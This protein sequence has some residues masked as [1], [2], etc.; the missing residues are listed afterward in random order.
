MN[1]PYL[2]L[3]RV[4]KR[5]VVVLMVLSLCFG[6]L[7]Q[8]QTTHAAPVLLTQASN[9]SS[10]TNLLGATL[11]LTPP[12][13]SLIVMI[14]TITAN[15]TISP[16]NG[17][18]TA[19][20][21]NGSATFPSQGIYYRIATGSESPTSTCSFS[22]SGRVAVQISAFSGVYAQP[23]IATGSTT[24]T[25]AL[26]DSGSVTTVN[27]NTLLIT[28]FLVGVGGSV[29]SW[30]NGFTQ[31]AAGNTGGNPNNRYVYGSAFRITDTIGSYSTA[32]T[33]STSANWRGQIVSF[34][35]VQ[36]T[37]NVGIV[38]ATGTPIS[39][40]TAFPATT[41]SFNCQ[42][43]ST[44]LFDTNKRLRLITESAANYSVT[45]NFSPNWLSPPNEYSAGDFEGDGCSFGQMTVTPTSPVLQKVAGTCA[46]TGTIF[47]ASQTLDVFSVGGMTALFASSNFTQDSCAWDL[48]GL[49]LSQKIPPEI[50]SGTYTNQATVTIQA[51]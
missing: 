37:T 15:A 17:Y 30:S 14:C 8:S 1:A 11:P 9:A 35:S 44:P 16:S 51:S 24:G 7:L 31:I 43:V 33:G 12:A 23:N 25:S 50:P 41:T 5:L 49:S 29:S 42:T 46:A 32:A 6:T 48:Y 28:G 27:N 26:Y 34:R 47:G 10:S 38:N 21:Q 40:N 22:A 3:Q 2:S 20:F 18:T 36:P 4:T 13:G 19:L 39:G 45:I